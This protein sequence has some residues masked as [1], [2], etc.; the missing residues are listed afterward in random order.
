M[1]LYMERSSI[2]CFPIYSNINHFKEIE[3][4]YDKETEITK[5]QSK[6]KPK[7]VV[8]HNFSSLQYWLKLILRNQQTQNNERWKIKQRKR[9]KLTV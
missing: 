3:G 2:F 6:I 1:I 7:Y 4:K 5:I 8:A 9:G